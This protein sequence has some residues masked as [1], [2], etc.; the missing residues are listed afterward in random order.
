MNKEKTSHIIIDGEAYSMINVTNSSRELIAS[1]GPD[2]I[3]EAKGYQ[4]ELVK[5][6]ET[7]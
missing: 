1:I 3:I 4:V 7:E 2:D 5:E 6:G